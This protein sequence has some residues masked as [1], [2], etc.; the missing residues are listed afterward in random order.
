MGNELEKIFTFKVGASVQDIFEFTTPPTCP[1]NWSQIKASR[2]LSIELQLRNDDYLRS[3]NVIAKYLKGSVHVFDPTED[4]SYDRLSCLLL[5]SPK[6]KN[7]KDLK[8]KTISI[9]DYKLCN[10]II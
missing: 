9:E 1:W 4:S 8:M 7:L 6:L 3:S 5:L 10:K 2:D